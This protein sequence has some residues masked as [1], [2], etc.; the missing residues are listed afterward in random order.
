[1]L[2]KDSEDDFEG[3]MMKKRMRGEIFFFLNSDFLLFF[4]HP[5]EEVLNLIYIVNRNCIL[6]LCCWY[7]SCI[8]VYCQFCGLFLCHVAMGVTRVT[9]NNCAYGY[10]FKV[11]GPLF[12]R[13]EM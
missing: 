2:D 12:E 3:Y 10:I 7:L 13:V 1:M 11:N 9:K 4:L 5:R 8:V 6:F